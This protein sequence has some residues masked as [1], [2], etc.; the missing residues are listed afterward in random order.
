M[1]GPFSLVVGPE[2]AGIRLDVWLAR[3]LPDI[4]RSRVQGLIEEG[5]ISVEGRPAKAHYKVRPGDRIAGVIPPP[6]RLEARPEPLELD[7]V[8]EDEDIIVVNKPQ[9]MVVHPAPGNER[10]TLV[11]ALLYHCRNL[12]GINGV[13]RPGIVHRLDKDTSGLL[14]AAKNDASHRS[15]VA[16]LKA[17]Q[18]KRVYLALVHGEISEPAGRI[19]AP[20]GRHPVDRQRMAVTFKNSRPAVTHYRVTEIFPGYTLVEALLETGRTHQIRVHMAYVGHPVVGDPKYGGRKQPFAVPGQLLHAARLGLFHPR[21]G[22]YLEFSAPLPEAFGRVLEELRRI[23][24]RT[25]RGGEGP[26]EKN[27]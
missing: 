4:S 22:R 9:G 21:T 1:T 8:Y 6:R 26:W 19:E 18:V 2:E 17:R 24:E 27:G 12:S 15:L 23:K 10:G 7:V 14:V 25:W 11:N 3:H 16:Q 5:L 13:L 20:I